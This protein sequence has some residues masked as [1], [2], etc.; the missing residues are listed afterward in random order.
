MVKQNPIRS[1]MA[2]K[3]KVIIRNKALPLFVYLV[4][5]DVD[6]NGLHNDGFSQGI[7]INYYWS[8]ISILNRHL[9]NIVYI[10]LQYMNMLVQAQSNPDNNNYGCFDADVQCK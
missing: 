7:W 1:Y 8:N 10:Y 3:L 6:F 4:F 2:S 9:K 5:V